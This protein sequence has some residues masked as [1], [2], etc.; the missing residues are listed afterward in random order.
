MTSPYLIW[1]GRPRSF[2]KIA[3]VEKGTHT[4]A[5]RGRTSVH[6]QHSP[7][8][9]RE[10]TSLI[11]IGHAFISLLRGHLNLSRER[12]RVVY[13][14]AFSAPAVDWTVSFSILLKH[15]L[16]AEK[17]I[18]KVPSTYADSITAKCLPDND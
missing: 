16:T 12:L 1:L 3:R 17:H 14:P 11:S 13:D 6:Y 10:R 2:R 9:F 4:C 15:F 5:P 18:L 7:A 8:P